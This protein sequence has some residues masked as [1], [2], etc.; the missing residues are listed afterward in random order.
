MHKK[1]VYPSSANNEGLFWFS[2]FTLTNAGGTYTDVE[3]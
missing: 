1:I 2:F 3:R